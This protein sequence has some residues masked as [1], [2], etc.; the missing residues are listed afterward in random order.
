[1]GKIKIAVGVTAKQLMDYGFT[2]NDK[3]NLYYVRQ[4]GDM[5]TLN[6]TVNKETLQG[7]KIDVLDESFLQ[8]YDYQYLLVENPNNLFARNVSNKVEQVLK[9]M[10]DDGIIDGYTSGMYV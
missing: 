1:M 3:P 8:P 5:T 6:I 9:E 4:V 10:Q 2:N 7:L